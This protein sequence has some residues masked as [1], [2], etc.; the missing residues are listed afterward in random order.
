VLPLSRDHKPNDEKEAIRV[1][2]S[3]G[4]IAKHIDAYGN[5]IGPERVYLRG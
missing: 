4:R 2:N 5:E 3:D 1:N